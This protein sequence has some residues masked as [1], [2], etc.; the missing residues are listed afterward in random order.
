MGSN[1]F[2]IFA[3]ILCSYLLQ[4][5]APRHVSLRSKQRSQNACSQPLAGISLGADT[6]DEVVSTSFDYIPEERPLHNGVDP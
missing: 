4:S 5:D 6:S 1:Q 3:N 2:I